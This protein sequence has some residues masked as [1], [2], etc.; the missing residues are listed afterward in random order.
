MGALGR[1]RGQLEAIGLADGG[2]I[3]L[4]GLAKPLNQLEAA[5]QQPAEPVCSFAHNQLMG[6]FGCDFDEG[7]DDCNVH[8]GERV[9]AATEPGCE[10]SGAIRL[11]HPDFDKS[12][13]CQQCGMNST[14]DGRTWFQPTS[15][16]AS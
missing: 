7:K 1:R 14:D 16:P 10:H 4:Y 11:F 3:E 12:F 5:L 15:E 8:P 13:T 6:I 2:L 9:Q